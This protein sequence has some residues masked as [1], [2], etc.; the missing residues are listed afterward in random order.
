MTEIPFPEDPRRSL[1]R[2]QV[3]WQEKLKPSL[4]GVLSPAVPESDSLLSL[5]AC[6]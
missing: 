2:Q 5:V 3:E 1:S 4:P 6:P